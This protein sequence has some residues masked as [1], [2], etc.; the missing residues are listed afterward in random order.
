VAAASHATAEEWDWKPVCLARQPIFDRSRQVIGYEL[1]QRVAAGETWHP[2]DS[3][4]TRQVIRKAILDFGLDHLIGTKDVYLNVPAECLALGE[5]EAF[6]ADRTVLEVLERVQVT[7]QLVADVGRARSLGYRIALDD[8]AGDRRFDPLLPLADVVKIDV[9]QCDAAAVSR[10]LDHLAQLAPKATILAE[11]VETE[12][13]LV[14]LLARP[15]SLFQ[16]YYFR[17]PILME[18]QPTPSADQVTLLK[19]SAAL[20]EPD[21]GLGQLAGIVSSDPR[22]AY[23]L[24]KVVN[25]AAF[26][27][28]RS[29]QSIH[30]AAVILGIDQIRRIVYLL[31]LA[32]HNRGPDELIALALIRARMCENLARLQ[33]GNGTA[34][35]TVGLFSLLDV[36]LGQP[37]E[38]VVTQLSLASDVCD[39]LVSR[40]GPLFDHLQTAISFEDDHTLDDRPPTPEAADLYLES[41]AWAEK[42]R[43]E[44]DHLAHPAGNEPH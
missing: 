12:A 44:I 23:Q 20:Q 24:I 40:R 42:L 10:V 13:V 1:L 25:S 4:V 21:I 39:A 17:R 43:S 6:P 32:A 18:T 34:A 29:I 7:D 28:P 5:Y 3:V 30:E 8:Y 37:V 31:T 35:F 27:M 9:E 36:A 11:K 22:L 15:V 33:Q 16:G 38:A 26:S 2:D 19:I 41:I 14:E